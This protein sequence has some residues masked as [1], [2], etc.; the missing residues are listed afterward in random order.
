MAQKKKE[1]ELTLFQKTGDNWDNKVFPPTL[2]KCTVPTK[3][4]QVRFLGRHPGDDVLTRHGRKN[5]WNPNIPFKYDEPGCG[6]W[7][8]YFAGNGKDSKGHQTKLWDVYLV[9]RKSINSVA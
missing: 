2:V 6:E 7:L 4:A 9:K 1:T 5:S 8:F 3:E